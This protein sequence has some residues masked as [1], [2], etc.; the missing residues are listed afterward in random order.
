MSPSP[1]YNRNEKKIR[2]RIDRP[3]L[4]IE[5]NVP[6]LLIIDSNVCLHKSLITPPYHFV[7]ISGDTSH[8][9]SKPIRLGSRTVIN[10]F[11][12]L[13][14]CLICQSKVWR[15]FFFL[16]SILFDHLK[17]HHLLWVLAYVR[18]T[19]TMM[20]KNQTNFFGQKNGNWIVIKQQRICLDKYL[21]LST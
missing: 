4:S 13:V 3:S 9:P 8:K 10:L 6:H 18:R 7:V 14:G 17:H 20:K 1:I 16:F 15:F 12:C 21:P 11:V 2:N 19:T 5:L